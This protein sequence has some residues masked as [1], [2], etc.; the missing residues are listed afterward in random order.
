[1]NISIEGQKVML[2]VIESVV[3]N[4]TMPKSTIKKRHIPNCHCNVF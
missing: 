3:S 1:M 2:C 4:S